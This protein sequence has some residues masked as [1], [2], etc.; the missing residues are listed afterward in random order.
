MKIPKAL[1]MGAL[2]LALAGCSGAGSGGVDTGDAAGVELTKTN[3]TETLAEAQQEVKT[4]HVTMSI[5]GAGQALQ[6]EGDI[7]AGD[8]VAESAM[9]LTMDLG[10][11]AGG[12][13]LEMR[14]VDEVFYLSMGEATGNKFA[15]IDLTDDSNPFAQQYGD[16]L[17]QI[18]PSKSVEQFEGAV[19]S[20]EKKGDPIELDG[21]DAQPYEI[22]V[23]TAAIAESSGQSADQFPAAEFPLTMYIGEDNLPRRVVTEFGEAKMQM[24]YTNWGQ[25]IEIEAPAAEEVTEESPFDQLAPPA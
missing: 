23:D 22:I 5:E 18:D 13:A 9:Q 1:A 14:L 10:E 8:S 20:F 25:D 7:I 16:L 3:F 6:A 12:Q 19:K 21:V 4:T 11:A 2:V 24:D 15:K 17:E